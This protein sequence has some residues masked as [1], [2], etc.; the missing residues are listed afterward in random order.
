M[1]WLFS[2]ICDENLITLFSD[3]T[4]ASIIRQ[5]ALKQAERERR[6][7]YK[8]QDD[9]REVIRSSIRGKV[10]FIILRYCNII[11]ISVPT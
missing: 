6:M 9:E 10:S 4:N 1:K 8:K 3:N 2:C 11:Y 7:K 5:E